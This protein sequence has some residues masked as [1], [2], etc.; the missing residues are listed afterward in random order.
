MS[1]LAQLHFANQS[2]NNPTNLPSQPFSPTGQRKS[3]RETETLVLHSEVLAGQLREDIAFEKT[4]VSK[5][6]KF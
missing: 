1:R 6:R 4:G 5:E 3:V 2:P